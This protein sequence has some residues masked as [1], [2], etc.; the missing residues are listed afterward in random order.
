MINLLP[1]DTREQISYAR[2]NRQLLRWCSFLA[3]SIV[4]LIVLVG[5]GLVYINQSSRVQAKEAERT[6]EQLRIQKLDETQGKVSEI[7]GNLKLAVQVLQRQIVFSGLIQQVASA[8]PSGAALT[9]LR[10]SKL[11]GG[12]DLEFEA[13][14]YQTATQV[15]VNL[16]DPNNK[17]F[18]KAD[19]VSI[20]CNGSSTDSPYP[21]QLTVR[22]L[23]AKNN[24]Y[25]LV[26]GQSEG[27]Q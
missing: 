27:T 23:F 16:Q 13:S 4:G 18:E 1:P 9:D 26:P 8:I 10:I 6:R 15:Q 12:I 21:C 14:D 11:Q 22:A 3:V 7:S 5:F 17:I 19:I 2:R 25:V 24:P 20:D